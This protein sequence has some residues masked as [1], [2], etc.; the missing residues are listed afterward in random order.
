MKPIQGYTC[1]QTVKRKLKDIITL[2]FLEK[3]Y[4]EGEKDPTKKVTAETTHD[5]MTTAVDE[6]GE[7]IFPRD[8]LLSIQQINEMGNQQNL[9][10]LKKNNKNQKRKK[11]EKEKKNEKK[12]KQNQIKNKHLVH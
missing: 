1:P 5:F 4:I 8:K 9:Y 10:N 12:K 3:N 11:K 6:N 2:L 7:R